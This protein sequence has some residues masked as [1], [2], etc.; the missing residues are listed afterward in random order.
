MNSLKASAQLLPLSLG[1]TLPGIEGAHLNIYCIN[2]WDLLK[3]PKSRQFIY[4]IKGQ[5]D[6]GSGKSQVCVL[7]YTTTCF[8]IKGLQPKLPMGG[9]YSFPLGKSCKVNCPVARSQKLKFRPDNKILRSLSL[10]RSC[11][12][13]Q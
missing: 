6:S 10:S 5:F 4:H 12:L 13:T 8:S 1:P 2:K 7:V 9:L 11:Q 3:S